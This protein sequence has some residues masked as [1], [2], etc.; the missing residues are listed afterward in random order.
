M[1]SHGQRRTP[2]HFTYP[3]ENSLGKLPRRL[4]LTF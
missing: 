3:F 2:Q 4:L 1:G